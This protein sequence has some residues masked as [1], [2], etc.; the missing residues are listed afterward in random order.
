VAT[1]A[2]S[3]LL[4]QTDDHLPHYAHAILKVFGQWVRPKCMGSKGRLPKKRLEDPEGLEYAIVHKEYRKGRV[5]A[6]ITKV[7]LGKEEDL[8]APLRSMGMQKI[9]TS[10]VERMNLTLR[11]LVSRL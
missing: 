9:N 10:F 5:I 4:L 1:I 2:E 6:V 7:V 8:M 3:F 11:P